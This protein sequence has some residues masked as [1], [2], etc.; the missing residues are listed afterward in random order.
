MLVFKQK[1]F[2][3]I[4]NIKLVHKITG[5]QRLFSSFYY[6]VWTPKVTPYVKVGPFQ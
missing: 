2:L 5:N 4:T 6:Q 3:P 1:Y